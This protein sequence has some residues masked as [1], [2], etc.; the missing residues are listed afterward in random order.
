MKFSLSVLL[1]RLSKD[2]SLHYAFYNQ[3]I[4]AYLE[5]D[6]NQV[7]FLA[8]VVINFKMPGQVLKDF[9]DRMKI[10]CLVCGE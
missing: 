5:L 6:P 8:P 7:T 2:E 10:I 9:D 1:T 3:V 4:Q